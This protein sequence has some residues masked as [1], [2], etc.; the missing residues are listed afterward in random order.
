MYNI[1]ANNSIVGEIHRAACKNACKNVHSLQA[2][3]QFHL[4]NSPI[5]KLSTFID[6]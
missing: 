2:H 5:S 1:K 4:L 3:V 6:I